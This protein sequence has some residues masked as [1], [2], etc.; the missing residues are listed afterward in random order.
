[1]DKSMNTSFD[2][3]R[4]KAIPFS[5][6][7]E[8]FDSLKRKGCRDVTYCP[9]HD[10]KHPSLTLYTTDGQNRCHCF[11]CG[12]GGST[13]DYVMAHE[14]LEF[15][16]ACQMLS[17]TFGIG[18]LA[19]KRK[20]PVYHKPKP[21]VHKTNDITFIP[22]DIVENMVSAEN[23]LSKCLMSLFSHQLV[24]YLTE[25]YKLGCYESSLYPDC[26]AFPS[27][28]IQGR[29]HNIKIQHYDDNLF[30][31]SFAHCDKNHIYWLGQK[32]VG[33]GILPKS[34]KFSTDCLFGEHLISLF[35]ATTIAL[36]ESP[37]NALFGAAAYPQMLWVATGTKNNLRPS[38]LQVLQG[39]DVIVYPDHDAYDEWTNSIRDVQNVANF[40]IAKTCENESELGK[41]YDLADLI[42]EWK[43]KSLSE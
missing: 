31:P 40:V 41:T 36:V 23:S 10:D 11:A 38:V 27:I 16:D 12:K 19:G 2:I 26:T 18:E 6:V 15:R 24:E 37:K 32:L 3:N 5:M 1:M 29:V 21:M 33:E 34:S 17:N 14:N 39:R 22:N 7:V 28:D 8:H 42:L 43:L 35:P 25:L 4:L 20:A 9:W 13:I 30:S